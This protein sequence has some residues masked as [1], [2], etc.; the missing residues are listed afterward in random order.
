ML[1]ND[2]CL[3]ETDDRLGEGIVVRVA[4]GTDRAGRAGVGEALGVANGEVLDAPVRVM[5]QTLEVAPAS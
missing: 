5:D 1:A 2:F 4:P 3:V